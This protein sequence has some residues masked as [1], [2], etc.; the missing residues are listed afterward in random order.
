MRRCDVVVI[1]YPQSDTI[2][3][4]SVGY[5]N[6]IHR[7]THTLDYATPFRMSTEIARGTVVGN[8]RYEVL[9]EIN[10]GGT[11][12]VY[13]GV[14]RAL[15]LDV[16]LK[17]IDTGA[18]AKVRVPLGAVKREIKYATKLS[19]KQNNSL[20][21]LMNVVNHGDLLILVWE[22]VR[23]SDV[24]DFINENGGYLRENV[25]RNL[26]S[27]LV[28]AIQTIHAQ[29]FCHR[30]IKPENAIISDGRLKL[31]DFG[32]AKSLESAKTRGIGTPD[33]MSPE[34]ISQDGEPKSGKYDAKACDVWSSA[35]MLYIMLTGKYPFQ[36]AQHPNNVKMTLRNIMDG[37]IAPITRNVS[38]QVEDLI[39]RMLNPDPAKRLT[40]REVA[41]HP[42]LTD[43][44]DEATREAKKKKVSSQ[45]IIM[46][47]LRRTFRSMT[48]SR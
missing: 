46:D 25:A 6:A 37:R 29:G 40:L 47:R 34:L 32:L 36:D 35:C 8:G 28:H 13:R 22:F 15:S 42:W 18:D 24:L 7:R 44:G 43:E 38:P 39:L 17:V 4:R 14:D 31:I 26:F 5:A 10:R 11:A 48:T 19:D 21:R 45:W 12:I 9:E 1:K 33:Y 27:Q 20:C 23:G 2:E 30:D 41:R 16:A 3:T